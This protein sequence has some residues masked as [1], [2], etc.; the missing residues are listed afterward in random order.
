MSTPPPSAF[1]GGEARRSAAAAAGAGAVA[2]GGAPPPP[3]AGTTDALLP[4]GLFLRGLALT[5]V[6]LLIS[7]LPPSASPAPSLRPLASRCAALPGWGAARAG[8]SRA[9]GAAP[10]RVLVLMLDDRV[11][12]ATLPPADSTGA[13]Y[14]S[15]AAVRNYLWARR[16][17][18]DFVHFHPAGGVPNASALGLGGAHTA[19]ARPACFN[20]YLRRWRALAWC[21]L[22]GVWAAS[23]ARPL[24]AASRFDL[25]LYLDSDAVV[26]DAA[27]NLSGAFARL[28]PRLRPRLDPPQVVGGVWRDNPDVVHAPLVY[29]QDAGPMGAPEGP[30]LFFYSDN[31]PNGQRFPCSGFFVA[32]DGGQLRPFLQTWWNAQIGADAARFDLSPHLEQAM[33]W[34]MMEERP[35]SPPTGVMERL[36]Q[37]AFAPWAPFDKAG[38]LTH[39]TSHETWE[40]GGNALPGGRPLFFWKVLGELALSP[41][42]WAATVA[43][44]RA[45]CHILPL[46]FAA[47]E[48]DLQRHAKGLEN[49]TE[50]ELWAPASPP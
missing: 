25:I 13:T 34:R 4:T 8:P 17:G 19:L 39:V 26:T 20:S 22:L 32:R 3:A 30:T 37:V 14:P 1:A 45:G 23:S 10:P 15:I 40:T 48:A 33:L 5:L 6:L 36:V 16:H 35:D 49:L 42:E 41:R 24:S 12:Q 2:G 44:M 11:P 29:G 43:E 7:L 50:A 28:Q 21:R 9:G 47:A 18:Y 38:W 31:Q 27:H 46:D